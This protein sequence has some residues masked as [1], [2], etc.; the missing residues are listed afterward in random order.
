M[1]QTQE[2]ANISNNGCNGVIYFSH[3]FVS[4]GSRPHEKLKSILLK[5]SVINDV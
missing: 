5:T 1:T 3:V 2:W 4:I